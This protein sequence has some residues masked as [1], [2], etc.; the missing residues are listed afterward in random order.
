LKESVAL[1][2]PAIIGLA[3]IASVVYLAVKGTPVPDVLKETMASVTA[4]Y[5]G[6]STV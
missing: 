3:S 5:F 6:R 1:F 4:Y 2:M